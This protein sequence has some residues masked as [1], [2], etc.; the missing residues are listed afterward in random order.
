[1]VEITI[2]GTPLAIKEGT[3][4]LRAAQSIG[5]EIP[6]LCSHE[7]LTPDGNCR[8]CSVEIEE[9]GKKK[10]VASCMYP[11]T[12]S[13]SVETESERVLRARR[14]VLTLLVNR[15]P[16]SPVIQQLCQK[17]GVTR[18]ER[19]AF[20]PDLCIRCGRCVRACEVNGTKAIA[21]VGRGFE[22][23]VATPFE[24]ETGACIGCLSCATVCPTGKITY[25][26]TPGKRKIWHKT[27]DVLRCKRCG[28]YFATKEMLDWAGRHEDDRDYCDHCQKYIESVKFLTQ[29]QKSLGE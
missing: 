9:H 26:E 18:E 3:T 28:A 14:T 6:V 2:N 16:K 4:I 5:V 25:E 7:G 17:Y 21:L 8:L 13:M 11:I 23:H 24:R 29:A 20:E 12:K 1:M 27:F 15:N 22:R 10:I 19:F